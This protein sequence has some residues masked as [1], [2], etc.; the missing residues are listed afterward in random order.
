MTP[1]PLLMALGEWLGRSA[2]KA[3]VN[4]FWAALNKHERKNPNVDKGVSGPS[5]TTAVRGGGS[6]REVFAEDY[7]KSQD[8][9]A[10]TTFATTALDLIKK[11]IMGDTTEGLM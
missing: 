4:K 8:D 11:S 2:T 7:A 10:E 5:G 6:N 3:E 9:Y 1:G